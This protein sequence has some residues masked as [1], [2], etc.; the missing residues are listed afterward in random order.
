MP[1]QMVKNTFLLPFRTDRKNNHM[2]LSAPFR[3]LF[4]LTLLIILLVF[5]NYKLIS[6]IFLF[7]ITILHFHKANLRRAFPLIFPALLIL[8]VLTLPAVFTRGETEIKWSIGGLELVMK[9]EG[10]NNMGIV[11]ARGLASVFLVTTLTT[12][13]TI[14]EFIQAHK[15][16]RVPRLFILTI[17]L[18]L[19]YTPLMIQEGREINTAQKL[20]GLET[21]SFKRRFKARG[22]LIG[23][24][25]IKSINKGTEVYEA[26]ILRGFGSGN[27]KTTPLKATDSIVFLCLM[28]QLAAIIWFAGGF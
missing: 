14:E 1:Q 11:L 19:R 17:L 5:P 3:L 22:A 12:T 27:E 24:T 15:A 6:L 25:I 20:R 10:L 23:S 21:A 18:I 16:L 4:V 9:E 2:V 28:A 7:G 8:F 13:M 26:M